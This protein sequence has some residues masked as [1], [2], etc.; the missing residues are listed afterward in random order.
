MQPM[1]HELDV[2]GLRCPL[3]YVRARA[4]VATLEPGDE[5]RVLATDP[6]ARIDLAALAADEQLAF[7]VAQAGEVLTITLRR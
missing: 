1:E 5:L 3:P 2:R 6:E 4:L 7:S